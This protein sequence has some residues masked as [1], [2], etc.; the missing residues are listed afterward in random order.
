MPSTLRPDLPAEGRY[1]TSELAMTILSNYDSI[2]Y[3]TLF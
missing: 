2:L 3:L 1:K